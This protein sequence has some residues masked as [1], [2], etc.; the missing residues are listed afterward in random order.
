VAAREKTERHSSTRE[1]LT[2]KWRLVLLVL[3]GTVLWREEP[4]LGFLQP[5][6]FHRYKMPLEKSSGGLSIIATEWTKNHP[7]LARTSSPTVG[8]PPANVNNNTLTALP[9]QSQTPSIGLRLCKSIAS[10]F[11]VLLILT[12]PVTIDCHPTSTHSLSPSVAVAIKRSDSYAIDPLTVNQ[13]FVSD[14]WFAVTAQF[15]DPTYNGMGE[16]GWKLK[17]EEAIAAVGKWGPNDRAKV[18]AIINTMLASLGDPYTR[19]LPPDQFE[20]LSSYA[21]GSSSSTTS[22]AGTVAGI[23]VQLMLVPKNSQGNDGSI[24]VVNMVR[25]GPAARGGVRVGDVVLQVDGI[26]M[27]DSTA[28]FVAAKCRGEEGSSVT[29]LVQHGGGEGS[30]KEKISIRRAATSTKF[31]SVDTSIFVSEYSGVPV[32]L[33]RV[34]SFTQTTAAELVTGM[35]EIATNQ[36]SGGGVS[37]IAIDLRG[38]V[39]G[40]MPAGIDAARKFLPARSA[41][42]AEIN[43]AG[44]GTY[45]FGDGIGS[46]T[47]MPLYVIV[48]GRTASAAEIFTAALKDNRRATIVGSTNTFGK[49]RIQNLQSLEDGSGISV[50]RARYITPRGRD[51]HGVGI[52]PNKLSEACGPEASVASCLDGLI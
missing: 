15:F 30:A 7:R 41:V 25:N 48:D 14:V 37:A 50:T 27:K 9:P 3:V 34:S 51:I 31:N 5:V 24:I 39:G 22:S 47:T 36:A 45:Y 40:Y 12:V 10:V 46:D 44:S 2:M 35:N 26:N 38:N 29:L 20:A 6:S 16:E 28:E 49:G 8:H 1:K 19:Y 43:R 52:S 18:D 42:V 32:G 33:L 13:R 11:L 21:R 23:G 17:K 4:A